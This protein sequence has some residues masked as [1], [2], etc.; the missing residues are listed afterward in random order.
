MMIEDIEVEEVEFVIAWMD[1]V[2]TEECELN[3]V[4]N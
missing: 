3:V 2:G 1:G 4:D